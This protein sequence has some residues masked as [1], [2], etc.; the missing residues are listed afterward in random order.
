L[1]A[2]SRAH[3]GSRSFKRVICRTLLAASL[4][5]GVAAAAPASESQEAEAGVHHRHDVAL[6]LGAAIRDEEETES[7][8]AL[9]LEYQYRLHRFLGVGALVEG[10]LGDLRDVLLVAPISLHPWRGLRLVVAPGAE[11]PNEGSTEFALRLGAGYKI[12]LGGRFTLVPE[13]NADLIEG[14]P[15][16]VFGVNLAVGF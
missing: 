11:I 14:H 9:G 7:G 6:F 2:R 16:Y 8:F 10:E 13:F 15:T 5:H 3:I 1:H 12:P 4:L